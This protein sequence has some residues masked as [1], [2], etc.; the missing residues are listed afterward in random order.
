MTPLKSDRL[1]TA[2]CLVM[3]LLFM[4][5]CASSRA[6]IPAEIPPRHGISEFK[7][8]R[9]AE[10]NDPWEG[11][12]RGMYRFNFYFDKFILLPVVR[13]YELVT[14]VFL[15][16]RVSNFYGNV[17]EIRNLTNSVFQAQGKQSLKTLGRFV[18]NS[19][20][21]IGGLFDPAT[22]LGLERH[23]EDFGQTLGYWGL[24]SGPYL[25]LPVAGP[26]SVRDAGGLAVDTGIYYGIYNAI[27]PF[28]NTGHSMAI[29]AAIST[30]EWVDRR[31][32]QDF[33]YYES[34]Y[35]F[36]YDMVRFFYHERR[37]LES[38]SSPK[39]PSSDPPAK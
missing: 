14:P 10:V 11:F 29:S 5:G 16:E 13:G 1:V 25:V 30:M 22:D 8:Q 15:Q 38:G 35:P 34:G 23:D 4:T 9:F 21:G 28:E 17:S 26:S 37:E 27:G 24:G 19:T 6:N 3:L 31:H 7:D 36:E 32:Q 12:N 18:T 33:R 2:A 39:K 20:I